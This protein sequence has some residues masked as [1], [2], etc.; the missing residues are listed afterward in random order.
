MLIEE[1][2]IFNLKVRKLHEKNSKMELIHLE[3]EIRSWL[4]DLGYIVEITNINE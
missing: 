3:S 4:E 1:Q 2:F